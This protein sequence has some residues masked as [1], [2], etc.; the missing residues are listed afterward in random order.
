MIIGCDRALESYYIIFKFLDFDEKFEVSIPDCRFKTYCGKNGF[1][2]RSVWDEPF[3]AIKDD[4]LIFPKL[5][6]VGFEMKK[7]FTNDKDRYNYLK[8]LYQALEEWS[9][10]WY[11]FKRDE[12]S[13]I[14][15]KD[16]I[17]TITSK[18]TESNLHVSHINRDNIINNICY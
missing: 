2:I 10:K 5:D 13:E 9:N 4:G 17:W 8:N 14:T 15:M 3:G 11:G 16:D 7:V 18:K 6:K 12:Y 1:R